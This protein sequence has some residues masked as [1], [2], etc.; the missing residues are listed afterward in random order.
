MF[1]ETRALRSE[2]NAAYRNKIGFKR[3]SPQI[4]G[5]KD[6]Q[7]F[8][9]D[10][11][12]KQK[13]TIE[14]AENYFN[15]HSK[16]IT[17]KLQRSYDKPINK[18]TSKRDFMNLVKEEINITHE[19]KMGFDKRK[20]VKRTLTRKSFKDYDKGEN[21]RDI[22]V[23]NFRKSKRLNE[24]GL[25]PYEQLQQ[26]IKGIG[27]D[28]KGTRTNLRNAEYIGKYKKGNEN[29]YFDVYKVKTRYGGKDIETYITIDTYTGNNIEVLDTDDFLRGNYEKKARKNK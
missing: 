20:I 2:I 16:E 17:N 9:K 5:S 4:K 13:K 28:F 23:E 10:R 21:W 14:Y 1:R 29:I 18:R 6:Y 22:F 3:L 12:I 15:R 24:N 8:Y 26:N 27:K 25:T 19:D 7:K 11:I